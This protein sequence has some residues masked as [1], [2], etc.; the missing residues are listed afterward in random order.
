M[1]VSGN[2]TLDKEDV[3]TAKAMA[4]QLIKSDVEELAVVGKLLEYLLLERESKQ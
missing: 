2:M 1:K 4:K 3:E